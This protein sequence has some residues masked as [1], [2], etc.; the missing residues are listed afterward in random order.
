MCEFQGWRDT[1]E[2]PDM[3]QTFE[4]SERCCQAGRTDATSLRTVSVAH[5]TDMFVKLQ[6]MVGCWGSSEF[7][8]FLAFKEQ[9]A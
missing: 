4:R 7:S 9:A 5:L 1:V 6:L 3:A 2:P 8:T